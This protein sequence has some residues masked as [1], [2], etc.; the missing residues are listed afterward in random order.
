MIVLLLLAPAVYRRCIDDFWRNTLRRTYVGLFLISWATLVVEVL[1]T[2]VFD[3]ILSPHLSFMV[4]TCAMFGLAVGGLFDMVRSPVDGASRP[5]LAVPASGFA[6]SVWMLPLLLNLI[7][8]SM[9][10]IGHEPL[11]Q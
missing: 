5:S 2:R 4:I 11:R 1:L 3:V 9:E 10:K 8:F 7:P 6:A